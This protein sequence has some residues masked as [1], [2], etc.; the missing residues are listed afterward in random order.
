MMDDYGRD[1]DF[2]CAFC[3]VGSDDEALLALNKKPLIC[4]RCAIKQ[5]DALAEACRN[6][7]TALNAAADCISTLVDL[8]NIGNDDRRI[9]RQFADVNDA[10]D[11]LAQ[12]EEGGE[13]D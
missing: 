6:A 8:A 3:G 9:L 1:G 4:I 7:K 5:R 13:R 10:I 12:L 2:K 11:A